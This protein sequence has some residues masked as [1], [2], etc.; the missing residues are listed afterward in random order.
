MAKEPKANAGHDADDFDGDF[1]LS[2]FSG[3]G[4]AN[5]SPPNARQK[6]TVR[7]PNPKSPSAAGRS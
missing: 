7:A 2:G 5:P 6:A 4:E 1:D 3:E